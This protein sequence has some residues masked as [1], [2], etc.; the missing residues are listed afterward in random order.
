[1]NRTED[2]K[3]AVASA[4][5]IIIKAG[6][7][8]LTDRKSIAALVDGIALVRDAGKRP[9]LVTSGAVGM[10]M[11]V[12]GLKRRPKELAKRQ[13][14]AAIGQTRLMAIYTEECA[15]HGFTAAQLLLT[16]A[17]LNARDRYLNV[18]NCVN[19]LWD[20]NVLPIINE[21]DSVSV[22]EL[23][24]GDN[25][26]LAGML[27]ALTGSELIVILTTETGLRGR[28][29]DGALGERISEVPKLT[30][31]IRALA[32]GT[33]DSEFSIGGMA[34]KLKAADIATATGAY[35]WIADGREKGILDR[36][37]R[38][39]DVGTLFLPRARI[40]GRKRWLRYF[41]KSSGTLVIDAG[42]AEALTKKG[43][44]LLPSG[45]REVRG[46]FRRG[47][48][49]DVVTEAG[50]TLARG[51]VNFDAVVC[52]RVRGRSSAQIREL[53]GA[54]AEEELVHR[55]NLTLMEI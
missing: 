37:L 46:N 1:M 16:A 22:A 50:R 47:D 5:Q 48:T 31:A 19:A 28:G 23:K 44:S 39:E 54:E 33:D 10:G 26:T 51:L 27:A 34:S 6:T 32:G 2:R 4:R 13:A 55:N 38:G 12:L 53:L 42:A 24:F 41:S 14:L 40:P 18:M 35:L 36:I 52:A 15:R 21:N 7:R 17:D 45:V 3:T 8:L 30:D 25:D 29:D 9:L 11:E 20:R 49:V 43:K